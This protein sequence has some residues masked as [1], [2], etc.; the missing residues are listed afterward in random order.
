MQSVRKRRLPTNPWKRCK[1]RIQDLRDKEV[2]LFH[3]VGRNIETDRRRNRL[4]PR[5][6]RNSVRSSI[7]ALTRRG[8]VLLVPQSAALRG[9][10]EVQGDSKFK[11]TGFSS[12]PESDSTLILEI[13]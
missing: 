7:G 6:Q 1:L 10:A 4:C 3:L 13:G 11:G 12:G 5:S 2:Y 8:D 9:F